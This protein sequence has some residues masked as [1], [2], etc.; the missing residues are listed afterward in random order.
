MEIKFE[1]NRLQIRPQ[2][3][4]RLRRVNILADTTDLSPV[5]RG[6]VHLAHLQCI[7]YQGTGIGIGALGGPEKGR[8]TVRA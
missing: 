2:S 3:G 8:D 1:K 7:Q 5:V 6:G 4:L